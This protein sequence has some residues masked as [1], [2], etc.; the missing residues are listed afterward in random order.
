MAQT[1]RNGREGS[2]SAYE[3]ASAKLADDR[4]AALVA[5]DVVTAVWGDAEVL[6]GDPPS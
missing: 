2:G 3:E 1:R 6:R 5:A 4:K